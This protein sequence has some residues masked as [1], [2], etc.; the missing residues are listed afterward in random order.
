MEL[1]ELVRKT[2]PGALLCS[3]IGYDLGDYASKGDMEVPPRNIEGDWETATPP[4]IPWSYAWYDQNWKDAREILLRLVAT[5]GAAG[6]TCSTSG[7]TARAACR[8]RSRSIS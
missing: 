7:R 4:T 1:A 6:P 8:R 5:V 3:R 2:Q